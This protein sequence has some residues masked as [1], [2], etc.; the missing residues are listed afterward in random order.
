[1]QTFKSPFLLPICGLCLLSVAAPFGLSP[2]VRAQTAPPKAVAAM[3]PQAGFYR[4]KIGTVTVTALS[5]GTL[6]ISLHDLLTHVKP[7]EINR[8]LSRAG[9]SEPVETSVNAYLIDTGSRL[10][11]VDTG[12]GDLYGSTVGSLAGSL[13]SA[14]VRPEQISDVL[15]THI[16]AD[17]SGGLMNGRALAFPN[18]VVH[19][20]KREADFWLNPK[21]AVNLS[22]ANK[23]RF[24]EAQDKV[25]PYV[26]AGKMHTFVG[27]AQ[28]FAGI[29]ALAAP[30]HTPGHT[31][32]VLESQGQ[33]LMFC[34]DLIH[35]TAV[36]FPNPDVTIAFDINPKQ[37][38]LTRKKFLLDAAK[39]GYWVAFDHVAFPGI[40]H[41]RA[42]ATGYQWIPINYSDDGRGQ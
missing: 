5:D 16:H 17:H 19:V 38:A 28:L 6:P 40:G 32:Y 1:M 15:L 35:A 3:P 24:I 31:I 10:I 11:L 2:S 29:R 39:R 25:G 22:A 4:V 42:G 27:N 26:K 37:A 14:G 9:L 8:S 33:K 13:R 7:G 34:G 30:G 23:K 21:N 36:Q 12:A 20:S 41:V 18:A